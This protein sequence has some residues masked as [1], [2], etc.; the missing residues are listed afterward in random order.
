VPAQAR[1]RIPRGIDPQSRERMAIA[2]SHPE[3][4]S[5]ET[6][7]PLAGGEGLGEKIPRSLRSLG[8]R[9]VTIR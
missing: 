6:M 3:K 2:T 9:S 7:T 8:M 1:R 4:P 5:F